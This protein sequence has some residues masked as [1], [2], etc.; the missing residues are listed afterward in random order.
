MPYFIGKNT[1]DVKALGCFFF[2]AKQE[3]GFAFIILPI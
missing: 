2:S 1:G 3:L